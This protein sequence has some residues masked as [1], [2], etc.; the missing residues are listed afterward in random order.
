MDIA[1][2]SGQRPLLSL[3]V[4]FFGDG[5]RSYFYKSY[6]VDIA[7]RRFHQLETR[8]AAVDK[9]GPRTL[10]AAG[11]LWGTPDA[12]DISFQRLPLDKAAQAEKFVIN[13]DL[14]LIYEKSVMRFLSD[15]SVLTI[16]HA[17]MTL[18]DIPQAKLGASRQN[19]D[20]MSLIH[21][22]KYG[23]SSSP[24]LS[25]NPISWNVDG[26]HEGPLLILFND[27]VR[28]LDVDTGFALAEYRVD[29]VKHRVHT[30]L[31]SGRVVAVYEDG[32]I[33]MLTLPTN[34]AGTMA[35]CDWATILIT[36]ILH[37]FSWKGVCSR[38]PSCQ[39][40]SMICRGTRL[41][42]AFLFSS[43]IFWERHD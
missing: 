17:G 38:D 5:T 25:T 18:M 41:P 8:T 31:S 2:A 7:G 6:H 14:E 16:T 35:T 30:S 21:K 1:F 11:R 39:G 32:S 24:P 19:G 29:R 34:I 26:R 13:L 20:I 10:T 27:C 42:A 40:I 9:L 3:G 37:V 15:H 22:W 23:G 36:F 28:V 43:T 12:D 33:C 4:F